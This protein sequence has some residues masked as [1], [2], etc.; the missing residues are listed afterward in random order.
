M[1]TPLTN[2]FPEQ[3]FS[4]F[5]VF[6]QFLISPNEGNKQT[7]VTRG[8]LPAGMIVPLH[9]HVEPEM[10]YVTEG[11][12]EIYREGD[13]WTKLQADDVFTVPMNIK[14]ALRNTSELPCTVLLIASG[15]ELNQFFRAV[16]QPI[17]RDWTPA[18]PTPAQMEQLCAAAAKYNYWMASPEE[19]AAIGLDLPSPVAA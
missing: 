9:S 11:S 5:G 6:A 17:E 2:K 19:N 8:F 16:A 18:P 3:T 15:A 12:F 10:F 1:Q 13:G 4:M 14:H 7:S